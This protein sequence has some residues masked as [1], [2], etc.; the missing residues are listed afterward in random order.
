MKLKFFKINP[1]LTD[2]SALSLLDLIL[3]ECYLVQISISGPSK[4]RK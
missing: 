4:N 2:L 3:Y 1:G